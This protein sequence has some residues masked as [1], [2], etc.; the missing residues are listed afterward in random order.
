M[1]YWW[2]PLRVARASKKRGIGL[3]SGLHLN[4]TFAVASFRAAAKVGFWF[5]DCCYAEPGFLTAWGFAFRMVPEENCDP[6]ETLSV[7][8]CL[9]S[10]VAHRELEGS[11]DVGLAPVSFQ[12]EVLSICP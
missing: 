11:V 1:S 9:G 3:S 10:M 7:F 2:Q 6:A 12:R 4:P 8:L 5:A